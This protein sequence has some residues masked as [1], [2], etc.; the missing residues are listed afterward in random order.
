M[1]KLLFIFQ[2][3]IATFPVGKTIDFFYFN[4]TSGLPNLWKASMSL[5]L[6]Y[7]FI[8]DIMEITVNSK[9]LSPVESGISLLIMFF[10]LPYCA[11]EFCCLKLTYLFPQFVT[12]LLQILI[13]FS[14]VPAKFV[15]AGPLQLQKTINK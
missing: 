1:C 13:F 15:F 2:N 14:Q 10:L 9:L 6:I 3:F 11:R 4:L 8:S 7:T 5:S 12:F